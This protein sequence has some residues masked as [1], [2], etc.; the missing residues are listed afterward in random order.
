M[1]NL[2]HDEYKP[3]C[4]VKMVWPNQW[5]DLDP[6]SRTAQFIESGFYAIILRVAPESDFSDREMVKVFDQNG[7]TSISSIYNWKIVSA[8]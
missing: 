4:L 3:G 8:R 1:S 2:P 5:C 7:Y 6:H